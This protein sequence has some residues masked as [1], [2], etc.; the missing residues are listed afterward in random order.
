M[1]PSIHSKTQALRI[2]LNSFP[3]SSCVF[4]ISRVLEVRL[5]NKILDRTIYQQFSTKPHETPYFYLNWFVH[6][7]FSGIPTQVPS[8][9]CPPLVQ[10]LNDWQASPGKDGGDLHVPSKQY[11]PGAC[12]K[13][14]QS[15]N[16]LF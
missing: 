16:M 9:Q 12:N 4:D 6:R 13:V 2:E 7:P 1:I 15:P 11:A 8:T 10:S 3:Q 5:D 14:L